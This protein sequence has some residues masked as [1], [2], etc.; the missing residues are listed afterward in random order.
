MGYLEA[1]D[2]GVRTAKTRTGYTGFYPPC[3]V[4]GMEVFS[5]NYIRGRKYRCKTCKAMQARITRQFARPAGA[6]RG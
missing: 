3:S 1:V 2:D 4:C 6:R 5:Q